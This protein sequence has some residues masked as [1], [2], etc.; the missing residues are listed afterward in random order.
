[1]ASFSIPPR[2]ARAE[3]LLRCNHAPRDAE[4]SEFRHVVQ[5][6]PVILA[7]LDE[8]INHLVQI[9]E[10]AQCRLNDSKAILH[11]IRSIPADV[12]GEIFRHCTPHA[13][14]RGSP[15]LLS[16]ICHRWRTQVLSSPNLWSFL[17]LKFDKHAPYISHT[18]CVYKTY[19]YLE[20]SKMCPLSVS[21][22][23]TSGIETHP[24]L[25]L[26]QASVGRWERLLTA[27]PVESLK[28]FSGIPF[29]ILRYLE[30]ELEKYSN[31][32]A[33]DVFASAP[34]LLS[35]R[36]IKSSSPL[37][38]VVLPWSNITEY[39]FANAYSFYGLPA[40]RKMIRLR[41]LC[42]SMVNTNKDS[43]IDDP[44]RFPELS[45]L[46]LN[47]WFAVP[48]ETLMKEFF[49]ALEVPSLVH[50]IL[51]FLTINNRIMHFPTAHSALSG[52]TKL[53]VQFQRNKRC[54]PDNGE[55]LLAFLSLTP[56]VVEL[57]FDAVPFTEQLVLGLHSTERLPCLRILDVNECFFD[58]D[59]LP[60]F[61]DML[62]TRCHVQPKPMDAAEAAGDNTAPATMELEDSSHGSR[63][64]YEMSTSRCILEKV[65]VPRWMYFS[66]LHRWRDILGAIKV[67]C[68]IT[69]S[70]NDTEGLSYVHDGT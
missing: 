53:S 8:Q 24:V 6:F 38:Y 32:T 31:G 35:L 18:Q 26:L 37:R 19:I 66:K 28:C 59:I 34:N 47:E 15:W 45:E 10:N 61:C 17:Q 68:G 2:T 39:Q 14:P 55:R 42:L 27:L 36:V 51:G 5:T 65:C 46:R 43:P 25:G 7:S 63:D 33:I 56:N 54:H 1:M 20:R 23:S 57:Q 30:I 48:S 21:L 44:I 49:E 29:S 60:E 11:P 9:R 64:M 13:R 62:E 58:D 41:K 67:E 12:L 69:Q 22:A 16:H 40:L 4:I 50:L 52:I 3:E 70:D